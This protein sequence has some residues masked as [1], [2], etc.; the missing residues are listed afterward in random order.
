[1]ASLAADSLATGRPLTFDITVLMQRASLSDTRDPI[2]IGLRADPDAQ[3]FGF[4]EFGSAES[5]VALRPRFR[6]ILSPPPTFGVP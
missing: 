2:R 3:T 5:P 6:V 4:W 1:S